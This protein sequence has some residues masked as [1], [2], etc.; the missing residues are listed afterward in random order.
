M[1]A[2]RLVFQS[3]SL[4]SA[5]MSQLLS[6]I[7][8]RIPEEKKTLLVKNT[9]SK[10]VPKDGDIGVCWGNT[11]G[12]DDPFK[13][14]VPTLNH[15]SNVVTV[16]NKGR[17]FAKIRDSSGS[18]DAP[19]TPESTTSRSVVASWL[20]SGHT[21]FARLVL[22]GN[23]GEGIVDI[24][25]PEQ[26]GSVPEGTLFT[27][28][29]PKKLEFRVHIGPDGEPFA[30]QRKAFS[31]PTQVGIEANWRIRNY[32]NGFIFE[33]GFDNRLLHND[34]VVQSQKAI[35]FFGLDF[36]AVDVVFNA[37]REEAYVLEI[38]TAPGLEGTTVDDYANMFLKLYE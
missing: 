33:R 24:S 17:F 27:K 7:R 37:K 9:G 16:C 30:I 3:Y 28:Y 35:K 29:V 20:S 23:S 34:V 18:A 36:G 11:S 10:Y 2:N 5:G 12:F 31:N 38:N 15:R 13:G 6:K 8:N 19:R 25:T 21:A 1:P 32:Q 22:S 26:L 14:R 4:A